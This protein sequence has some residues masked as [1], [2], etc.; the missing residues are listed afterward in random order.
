MSRRYRLRRRNECGRFRRRRRPQIGEM[1]MRRTP[2]GFIDAVR[3]CSGAVAGIAK[4]V[5]RDLRRNFLKTTAAGFSTLPTLGR[6]AFAAEPLKVG[7]IY[8]WPI[9][10]SRQPI[11]IR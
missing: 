8:L 10:C 7:L 9:G 1:L 2:G 4:R 11:V 6:R 3:A 5:S